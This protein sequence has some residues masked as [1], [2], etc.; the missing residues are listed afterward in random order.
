MGGT[1]LA[2]GSPPWTDSLVSCVLRVW[3]DPAGAV[4]PLVGWRWLHGICGQTREQRKSI[5]RAKGALLHREPS[6]KQSIMSPCRDF[7][8]TPENGNALLIS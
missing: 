4:P 5:S 6:I 1:C 2:C 7:C 3:L 8:A